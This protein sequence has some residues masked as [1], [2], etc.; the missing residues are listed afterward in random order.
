M[1]NS[2]MMRSE[3]FLNRNIS[4]DC[5]KTLSNIV[6]KKGKSRLSVL[7]SQE[8]MPVMWLKDL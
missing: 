2:W 8:R 3:E 6:T 5:L 4:S 7:S 1:K